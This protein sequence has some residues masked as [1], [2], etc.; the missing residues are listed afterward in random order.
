MENLEIDLADYKIILSHKGRIDGLV[1]F[2]KIDEFI[3]QFDDSFKN[4]LLNAKGI[5]VVFSF[6][7]KHSFDFTGYHLEKIYSYT[8]NNA[9]IIF[10][11]EIDDNIDMDIVNYQIIIT[12]L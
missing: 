5:L 2:C 9:E 12:G 8:N 1:G 4:S 11:T 10:G 6:N 3:N 7:S